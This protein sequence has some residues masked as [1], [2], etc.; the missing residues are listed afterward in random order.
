[1]H[2]AATLAN[3]MTMNPLNLTAKALKCTLVLDPEGLAGAAGIA[4]RAV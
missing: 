4:A 3:T 2:A 1:L